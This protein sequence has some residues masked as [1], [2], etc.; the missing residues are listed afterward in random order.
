MIV[1][2]GSLGSIRMKLWY[3]LVCW[4]EQG[5]AIGALWTTLIFYP[6]DVAKTRLQADADDDEA[7]EAT[8]SGENGA[9]LKEEPRPDDA[10]LGQS[11]QAVQKPLK[12]RRPADGHHTRTYIDELRLLL[13]KPEL[14]YA[15][16]GEYRAC[17]QFCCP[18]VLD[19]E[20]QEGHI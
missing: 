14:W 16:V 2:C 13:S 17:E 4:A 7:G 5:G 1:D 12:R 11:V 18:R 19:P 10:E 8:T 15:G 6:I 3:F 9:E 20:L